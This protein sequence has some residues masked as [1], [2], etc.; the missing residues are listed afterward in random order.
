M[1]THLDLRYLHFLHRIQAIIFCGT[2]R[3]GSNVAAW[4]GI[5]TKLA[6]VA[7][8]DANSKLLSDLRVDSEILDLVQEDL[9]NFYTTF[10]WRF[11]PFK[12]EELLLGWKE[13][14]AR[15]VLVSHLF[16][17]HADFHPIG[18]WWLFFQAWLVPWNSWNHRRRSPRNGP[19]DRDEG[20]SEC[21]QKTRGRNCEDQTTWSELLVKP[22]TFHLWSRM[23]LLSMNWFITIHTWVARC[24]GSFYYIHQCDYLFYS[25]VA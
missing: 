16:S 23:Q 4:G 20:Y 6:A 1:Q 11:I 9:L 19:Q 14:M 8:M 21:S 2:P 13:W 10:P 22:P 18:S 15:Q 24:A 7:L 5:A 12:R 3:R 25:K 17:N